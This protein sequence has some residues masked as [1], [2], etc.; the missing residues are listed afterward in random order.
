MTIDEK[1]YRGGHD[2]YVCWFCGRTIKWPKI[3]QSLPNRTCGPHVDEKGES[4][5][6]SMQ[7][8]DEIRKSNESQAQAE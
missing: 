1:N 8:L 5:M 6:T 7:T 4:F 3:N 2:I